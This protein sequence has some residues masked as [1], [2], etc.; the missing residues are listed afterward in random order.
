ML[1]NC[2]KVACKIASN[3][4]L[5]DFSKYE[6]NSHAQILT[7]AALYFTILELTS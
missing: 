7:G 6:I 4:K 5:S 2:F 3:L 1:E